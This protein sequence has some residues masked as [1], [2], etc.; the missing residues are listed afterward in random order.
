MKIL[1]TGAAGF[2]GSH[3]VHALLDQGHVVFGVDNMS[4]GRFSNIEKCFNGGNFVFLE[5][6]YTNIL[7]QV[8]FADWVIHLAGVGSVPR[9]IAN[10]ELTFEH[11]VNKFHDLLCAMKDSS[12]KKLIYASSSSVLGG[13]TE[14][15]PLSPYALSKFTNELY[16]RQ[17]SKF[18]GIKCV[19]LRFFNVYGKNQRSDSP[20][21]AVIPKMLTE[22][23]IRIN[24][25]GTQ[26]RDFTYVKDVVSAITSII[27]SSHLP[28]K[29]LVYNVG[30]GESR[31][32]YELLQILK[33]LLPE[34]R[35]DFELVDQRPGD[36]HL[37]LC[38][39]SEI[40]NDTGWAPQYNLESGLNDM[41]HGSE[42]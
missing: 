34:R 1:V 38:N 19:G 22:E 7:D 2:I 20:Y 3:L 12:C 32:L 10:P 21:A 33:R 28:G 26:S 31:N 6:C 13:G 27:G 25:P 23:K 37:S 29:N 24:K 30:Y 36:I 4:N 18:Y 40:K 16:A 39:N 9:S 41:L 17:F 42:I 11:N 15:N 35:F 5:D 8:E 14:P